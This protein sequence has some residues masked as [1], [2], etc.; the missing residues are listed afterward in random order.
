MPIVAAVFA[1]IGR[2]VGRL[3]TMAFGWASVMLFGRVPQ[4]KQVLLAAVA[5]G[6]IAWAVALVGV[7]VPPVGSMLVST[8]P[9]P[10]W[11]DDGWLRLGMVV[12]AIGLP[13]L[14]GVGGLF[15]TE[16]GKRPSGI[17]GIVTQVLRGYP[18]SAVLALTLAV[19]IVVAPIRK[20]RSLVKRWEDAHIPMIVHPGGYERVADDLEA[21][22]DAA[23]L[24][25]E[26][27]PAPWILETPSKLLALAGGPSVRSLVP[28]RLLV[29]RSPTLEVTIHP[30]DVAIAGRREEVA[31]AR[32]AIASR[33]T[34]TAAYL[35]AT[36]EGQRIED[37]LL[38][39]AAGPP[40]EAALGL[41]EIDRRLASVVVGE[42]E[43]EVLYRERLQIERD[44]LRARQEGR[45]EVSRRPSAL[46]WITRLVRALLP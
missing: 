24:H 38:A 26:R 15:L 44:L 25:V 7:L 22:L 4:S 19:L 1:L 33:M 41:Q 16:A 13:L 6:A 30:T 2:F 39:V 10:D 20:V 37:R 46:G 31:K 29:L 40:D 14:V 43:W 3:L 27:D 34:F 11:V 17:G 32:A 9:A 8:T 36:K 5:L 45:R 21:A 28:D 12:M 18:Y 35:T 42:E 23:G